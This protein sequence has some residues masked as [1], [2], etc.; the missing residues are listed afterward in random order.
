MKKIIIVLLL[1]FSTTIFAQQSF[2]YS[3]TLTA[4]PVRITALES[5]NLSSTTNPLIG[6]QYITIIGVAS[7]EV[8]FS[9]GDSLFATKT[10]M[11]FGADKPILIYNEWLPKHHNSTLGYPMIWIKSTSGTINLS[12]QNKLN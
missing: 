4:T 9:F 6:K 5:G 8:Q 11:I 7:G 12:T 10:T 1:F 2:Y 3:T